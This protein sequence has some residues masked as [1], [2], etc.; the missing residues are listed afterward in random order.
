MVKNKIYYVPGLFSLLG[1][2]VI[3][4]F[5]ILKTRFSTMRCVFFCR[6]NRAT[7]RA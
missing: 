5:Y 1:L 2:P 3:F 4:F 7:D 6:R